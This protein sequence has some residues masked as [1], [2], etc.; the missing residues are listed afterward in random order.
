MKITIERELDIEDLFDDMTRDFAD[1]YAVCEGAGMLNE[2]FTPDVLADIFS[3]LAEVAA[4]R[5]ARAAKA[6][7]E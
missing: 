5:A 2:D 1:D 3:E 4:K 6:K 7:R